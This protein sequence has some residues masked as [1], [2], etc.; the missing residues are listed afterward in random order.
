MHRLFQALICVNLL[1]FGLQLYSPFESLAFDWMQLVSAQIQ[2]V[3]Y[4]PIKFLQDIEDFASH[5][6]CVD[7]IESDRVQTFDDRIQ[8]AMKEVKGGL[9]S[10][11]WDLCRQAVKDNAVVQGQ[12]R[13]GSDKFLVK[14][15]SS[16]D[17]CASSGDGV[18]KLFESAVDAAIK[19][20][21]PDIKSPH[22]T[23]RVAA[24]EDSAERVSR[25]FQSLHDYGAQL[26]YL[27]SAESI[28]KEKSADLKG[29]IRNLSMLP[30]LKK[31]LPLSR[32]TVSDIKCR[33]SSS[34]NAIPLSSKLSK[35]KTLHEQ[36]SETST[37]SRKLA[38][39]VVVKKTATVEKR[40]KDFT[41]STSPLKRAKLA[42]HVVL[43]ASWL[44]VDL[45]RVPNGQSMDS[46]FSLESGH[47]DSARCNSEAEQ[48][49]LTAAGTGTGTATIEDQTNIIKSKYIGV[50]ALMKV[51]NQKTRT[52]SGSSGPATTSAGELDFVARVLLLG[53]DVN[54]GMFTTEEAAAR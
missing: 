39:P 4:N 18:T 21:I 3:S 5:V 50:H 7:G 37:V 12:K 53:R 8:M 11:N 34:A 44:K 17:H 52:G 2:S 23:S 48:E 42:G 14:A 54:L 29:T 15:K 47:I 25:I 40:N 9:A 49:S 20:T 30:S 6:R 28:K 32:M 10:N 35:S 41:D 45:S 1:C 43:S 26:G 24:I 36:P 27:M 33:S 31:Q 16:S 51:S 22:D 46:T 19:P 38:A 13:K